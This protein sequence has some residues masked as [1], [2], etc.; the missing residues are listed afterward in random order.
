VTDFIQP[1]V[2]QTVADHPDV[3]EQWRAGTPKTWGFLAGRAVG[4]ARRAAGRDLT[5]TERRRVWASL[6]A[7][8]QFM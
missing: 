6:W 1:A 2:E 4:N 5:E 3:V 8:L 7:R